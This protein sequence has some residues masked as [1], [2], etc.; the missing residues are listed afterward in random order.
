[1]SRF[2]VRRFHDGF[3]GACFIDLQSVLGPEEIVRRDLATAIGESE[4][5]NIQVPPF[6]QIDHFF[7]SGAGF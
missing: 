5:I 2:D 7:E 4:A 3:R 6:D 1:M